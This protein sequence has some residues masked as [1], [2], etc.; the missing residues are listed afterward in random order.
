M[1]SK[2][3]D[4]DVSAN[5]QL[6]LSD[7]S[8][9]STTGLQGRAISG[10][11]NRKAHL[12]AGQQP[13]GRGTRVFRRVTAGQDMAAASANREQL[14]NKAAAGAPTTAPATRMEMAAVTMT[15]GEHH[16]C[17]PL[18]VPVGGLSRS[19]TPRKTT[20]AGALQANNESTTGAKGAVLP[21]RL[22]FCGHTAS[23]LW[24]CH[25]NS[26]HVARL[27]AAPVDHQMCKAPG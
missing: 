17:H 7:A 22:K 25:R 9:T 15:V 21:L 2:I 24:Q 18:E 13:M 10:P 11:D 4:L 5:R 8:V 16:A 19:S 3:T 12:P 27:L 14:T 26:A 23:R 20:V 6:Q 1:A